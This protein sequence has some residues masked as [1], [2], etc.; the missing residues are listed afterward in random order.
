[1]T[2]RVRRVAEIKREIE[3]MTPEQLSR[4]MELLTRLQNGESIENLIEEAE[5]HAR[6]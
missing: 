4:F 3:D 1:M 2:K 6:E 5:S